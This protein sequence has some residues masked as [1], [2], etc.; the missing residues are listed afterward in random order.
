MRRWRQNVFTFFFQ[1]IVRLN[2]FTTFAVRL[3]K[4]K[5]FDINADI[6]QLARARDL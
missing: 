2:L 4:R 1:G 6:A 5:Y 3:T